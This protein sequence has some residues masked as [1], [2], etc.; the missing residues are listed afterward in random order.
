VSPEA[1]RLHDGAVIVDLH[2]DSLLWG[3]DLLAQSPQGQVDVPRLLR[4]GVAV[5]VFGLV[6]QSPEGMNF[7]RNSADTDRIRMLVMATG[8]PPRTWDSFVARAEYQLQRLQAMAA[9]S[10]GVLRRIA[11][12]ADLASVVAARRDGQQVVG[13]FGGLE[14]AHAAAHVA[15][16]ERLHAAG[17]RMIGLAHFIDSPLA[18]SAHGMAKHGL[19]EAGREVVREAE[20][21]GVAIDLAHASPRTIDEVLAMAAKPVVVSHG[22]VAGTCPGP[23]TLTDVQLRGIAATGGVVGIGFFNG[24]V[25]GEDVKSIARA[26][27]YAIGI[28][29][30]DHVGLG[31]DWDG[32]VTTPFDASGLPVL[33]QELLDRGLAPGT[34]EKVLGGNA[35]RVLAQTLPDS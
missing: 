7:E 22:G 5:Q 3:R 24:A 18:G 34:I 20:R 10:D 9:D 17:L 32:S 11:T 26:I 15:A 12:R 33:T 21:L 8:W 6:T 2:A 25:C 29:G 4:G 13:A 14:G 28:A 31:S 30:A 16:L 23:R 35:L 27:V 19:T 1:Q